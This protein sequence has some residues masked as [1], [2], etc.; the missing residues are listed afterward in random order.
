MILT[1]LNKFLKLGIVYLMFFLI[2]DAVVSNFFINKKIENNCY[3]WLDNFY[4]LKKNC[5]AKEKWI[6]KSK[7]YKVFTD[8]N[9]FRYSGKI[10]KDNKTK[11]AIFF[12]GSFTYG[13]GTSHEKSFVGLIE[14]KK[15]ITIF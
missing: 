12:G 2:G 11:T 3:K 9:G 14:K 7:S 13:M 5:Y 10:K 6:K 1:K 4:H 8:E 15:M